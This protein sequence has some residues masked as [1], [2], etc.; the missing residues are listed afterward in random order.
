MHGGAKL[1]FGPFIA[2]GG[3]GPGRYNFNAISVSC[4]FKHWVIFRMRLWTVLILLPLSSCNPLFGM[5]THIGRELQAGDLNY[6]S[7][8]PTPQRFVTIE[9]AAPATVDIQLRAFYLTDGRETCRSASSFIAGSVEG[10][11]SPSAVSIPVALSNVGNG[12]EGILAVDAFKPGRCDWQFGYLEAILIKGSLVSLPNIV[13][14]GR[15]GWKMEYAQTAYA[16]SSA[17]PVTLRCD[18]RGLEHQ[19]KNVRSNACA[20]P[21]PDR[22]KREQY[23]SLET[24][25][26]RLEVEDVGART[27]GP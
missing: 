20:L 10:A 8:N 19:G 13:V 14:R 7:L 22:P 9:I 27:S 24:S 21:N 6:P 11:T 4:E 25:V 23:L 26:V 1:V 16:N 5:Y 2:V 17:T 18:F 12:R 3:V 15:D